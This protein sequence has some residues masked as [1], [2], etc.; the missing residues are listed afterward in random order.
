MKGLLSAIILTLFLTRAVAQ[1]ACPPGYMERNVKCNGKIGA[2]CVPENYTCNK[3]WILDFAPC[4]GRKLGG[5]WFYGSYEKALK[6]ANKESSNWHDGKC[7]WYD[8]TNFTIYIDD[9]KYCSA[10]PDGNV[11]VKNDLLSKIKPFLQRYKAEITNYQRYFNGQPYKPGA[12]TKEYQTQ[13]K[14]AEDNVSRLEAMTNNLN[15]NNLAEIENMFNDMQR[16]EQNLKQSDANFR[17]NTNASRQEEINN[18]QAEQTKRQNEQRLENQRKTQ[19]KIDAQMADISR[20]SK[21]QAEVASTI[22]DGLGSMMN[23]YLVNQAKRSIAED[24]RKRSQK[25]EELKRQVQSEEGEL[26]DCSSCNGEGYDRCN[27]CSS[28]GKKTCGVCYGKAGENCAVCKGSGTY[29][30]GSTTLSCT[31]C[32]GKGKISCTSCGN[33]GESLCI[34]CN[35]LGKTQC[36]H[37]SGTGQEFKRSY[38]RRY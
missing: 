1:I 7:T 19:E 37:C 23:T 29:A 4:P 10:A 12:V 21:A 5:S 14:Q 16:E 3:C 17:N 13:L 22:V 31:S 33:T 9:E 27:T 8:N 24:N 26:V 2:K 34:I 6:A 15:D 30:V 28:N 20:K 18:Q 32:F 35:G 38:S 36:I 11:A 25:F